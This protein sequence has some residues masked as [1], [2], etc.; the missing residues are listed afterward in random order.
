MCESRQAS[1]WDR[2]T[3]LA[4]L[5][6]ASTLA[7]AVLAAAGLMAGTL[8]SSRARADAAADGDNLALQEIVVSANR[9]GDES[10]QK[11]PMA[12]SVISPA[13]LDAKGL[14]GISDFVGEL[15]S[16]NMQ[17]VSPGENVIDMRGLV[18]NEVDPTNVQERSL[19][20]LYLD[21]SSIGLEGFNPDLHVYDLERV[22][23]IRGPQGTLYGAGSMAGT[24]RL[25]TKKPDPTAFLGD[26]DL[27]VSETQH[28][29]TNTSIRGM[30]NLPLID[31][32][33]AA[34]LV[35]YRSD[36]SGYIDNVE[37]GRRDANP[38]Y[39]T[40]GRL[41]VRWLPSDTFTLDVSALFARLNAQGRNTV[42]PQLGA[43]TY[44]SLTPEQLS[45]DFKLYNITAD[46]D[47]SFAHLISSSSYTQRQI[48]EDE[49]FESLDEFLITPGVRLPAGNQN[50]N[51]L[52]EFQ[53]ELRL[54]SRPDQ[55][56]RWIAGAYFERDSR[57][58]PQNLT[59]PGFDSAFGAEIGDP[60]FSS[61][62]AY[63]TPAPDTPFYG[64]INLVER[65][66]ALFGE[67]TYS[68]LPRLDLTLGARYFN[69]KDDFDLYFTG[70][71]GAIAPGEPDTG[72]GEQR[73]TGVNPR[74]VL[75]FKV[76][77]QVIV[78]GEA[79]RGF[80]Y[81]GVN[82]PA[83]V[84]FCANDLEALGLKESPP[85][86]GPDHLWSYTLGE[87]GTF[88]EG[89]WTMN[90]DAFYIDWDDVQTQHLLT[91]GYSFAQ[92]AGKITSQGLEWDSKVRATSALTLGLSGSYTDATA[93][94]P[95]VNL[96]ATSGDRAPFFP[97]NIVT[98]SADYDIPLP[99]GKIEIS[100]DYTYRSRAFTDFS[101][102][103]FDYTVIPSSVVLNGSIGY[104]TDR[105]SLS[106]FGTN[107]T[108]N[109]LVSIVDV[110]TNGPYQ[111][112]NLEYWGRPR[113]IGVHAH[114][115]F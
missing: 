64:T 35:L 52:H 111:P 69:F 80:R 83:P 98:A 101:P 49:S 112:G 63:G 107:L 89:R 79:A 59:S 82:E 75:T 66:F 22:E 67:A 70:V 5:P 27:S 10:V 72:N 96:G 2:A 13:A 102:T 1:I 103:A 57:F 91:C 23:V 45:D 115:K 24:I 25:I 6:S 100:T 44:E 16:V 61:Q 30:V 32:K 38:A 50:G 15:P 93:D 28:G 58:Y 18:T 47:L 12:I 105:W 113:T 109:H 21:D 42:Y 20:A 56:L 114:V 34:R 86:F 77:D 81:G 106:V 37:L 43:Y 33:L 26:A 95:I 85:S 11:I 104:V 31:D 110:N 54:V 40:Q 65:Q 39:A 41:A 14:S 73:S 8:G 71:A 51:E 99:Q 60:T 36:D 92:N 53:Q 19:V 48:T 84:I 68:I 90:V 88:A 87:K 62:S 4:A 17:S 7:V 29:G 55:P 74:G 46:W 3:N 97:R 108:N 94:G 78:Y 9:R 76:N